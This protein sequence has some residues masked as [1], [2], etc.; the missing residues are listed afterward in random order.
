MNRLGVGGPEGVEAVGVLWL[1]RVR[2]RFPRLNGCGGGGV[3]KRKKRL[4]SKA[5]TQLDVKQMLSWGSGLVLEDGAPQRHD[6][7]GHLGQQGHAPQNGEGDGLLQEA[8]STRP[9]APQVGHAAV[10]RRRHP[11]DIVARIQ[12]GERRR[13]SD[14]PG[15]EH[16]QTITTLSVFDL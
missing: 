6:G 5:I 1:Q 13:Q 14:Q 11:A 15:K 8:R 16:T 9:P 10:G 2:E 4:F 7:D 3:R 12:G